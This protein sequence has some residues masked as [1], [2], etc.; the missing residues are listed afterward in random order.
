VG[1][2]AVKLDI[3]RTAIPMRG[4]EHAAARRDLAEAIV[5]RVELSDGR[6]GWGETLPRSYVTGETLD[7]VAADLESLF[8]PAVAVADLSGGEFPVLSIAA[9][10]QRCINAAACAMEL[11]L[12]DAMLDHGGWARLGGG[13]LSARIVARATGVLGSSDPRKTAR[14]LRL[15]RWFGLRDFKLKLGFSPEVDQA[16]LAAV[17]G[18]LGRALAAGRCSLRVDING[19][20]TAADTPAKAERLG[21]LGVCVVEQPVYCGAKGLAELARRCPLP[22]MADESLLSEADARDLLTAGAKVWWN[23]R[24]SKNGGLRR[25]LALARLAADNGVPFVLGCM[26]GESSILSAAQRRLLQLSPPPRFVEGN[27]GRFLMGDDLAGRSLR[28]GYGGRLKPLEGRG[29]G[30]EI[31]PAKLARYGRRVASLTG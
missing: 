17:A 19:G 6:C 7:T 5:T 23:I 12:A 25:S 31:S 3:F 8:W 4:F 21:Q 11:A 20:W 30:V 29:L 22:L 16:N 28:F 10:G 13:G 1:L 15:M 24:L 26:V 14:K 18:Q 2:R 27:Y 9:P